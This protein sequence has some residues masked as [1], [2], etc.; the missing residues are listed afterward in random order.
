MLIALI[1][2]YNPIKTLPD[3]IDELIASQIFYRIILVND[4]SHPEHRLIFDALQKKTNVIFLEHAI[5]QGKGAALKTGLNEVALHFPEAMGVVTID[6]DGQHCIKDAC[7]VAETLQKHPTHLIVGGRKFDTQTPARSAVGNFLTRHLFKL[8]TGLKIHD[9]Q[10]GLRGIPFAMIKPLLNI[11]S[12]GY[13]YELDM[14]MQSQRLGFKILETPITTIY[15]NDNQHSS[16]RPILDSLR[17]YFVLFRFSIIAGLSALLDYGIFILIYYLIDKNVFAALV[18][19][20]I[21]S[22]TFN[23]LNVRKFAFK[24]SG[25]QHHRTLPKYLL[26]A[27][28]SG[29]IAYFFIIG[30][31]SIFGWH[32]VPAKIAAEIIMFVVNFFIQRNLIFR[33]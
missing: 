14:L 26:L 25:M 21:C 23:Y 32:V 22:I 31:M 9:T 2:A 17:I 18:C 16:F 1:P 8:M 33:K 11:E 28:F 12:N 20:R 24:A 4:G 27:C 7:K 10:S 5:N 29:L 15:L 6:A 19:S 3:Y 30:F 13:E